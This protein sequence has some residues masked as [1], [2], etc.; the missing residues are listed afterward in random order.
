MVEEGNRVAFEVLK[1]QP[2][3]SSRTTAAANHS[4]VVTVTEKATGKFLYKVRS[5]SETSIAFG[6]LTGGEIVVR[7]TDSFVQAGGVTVKNNSFVGNIAGVVVH[8]SG[9]IG[10]GGVIPVSVLRLFEPKAA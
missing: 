10:V 4:G 6:T 3:D 1:N 2:G 9:G 7:I 5:G 8:E